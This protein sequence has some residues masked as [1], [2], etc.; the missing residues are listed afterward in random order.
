MGLLLPHRW[1]LTYSQW[2]ECDFITEGIID[3]GESSPLVSPMLGCSSVRAHAVSAALGEAVLLCPHEV[4]PVSPLPCQHCCCPREGGS[5]AR[6]CGSVSGPGVS[7]P[8]QPVPPLQVVAFGTA[9]QMCQRSCV[10]ARAMSQCPC[11]SLCAPLIRFGI[12]LS[13]CPGQGSQSAD[14]GVLTLS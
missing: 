14:P 7:G 13:A 8:N 3:N 4:V 9:C 6:S 10:P 5:L 2:W 11:P 12:P 1:P